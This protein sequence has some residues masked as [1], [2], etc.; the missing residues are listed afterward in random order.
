MAGASGST[1]S[2]GAL[3]CAAR[4]GFS[5]LEPPD[6]V[7]QDPSWGAATERDVSLGGFNQFARTLNASL[8]SA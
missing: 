2:V 8:R 5:K 3:S 4:W 7:S 6:G 1:V